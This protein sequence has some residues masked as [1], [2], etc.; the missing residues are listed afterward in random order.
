MCG[1][2]GFVGNWDKG[3]KVALA[4]LMGLET[5]VRGKD[6]TGVFCAAK[7]DYFSYKWAVPANK[8]FTGKNLTKIAKIIEKST[9]FIGHNRMASIGQVNNE[10]AHPFMSNRYALVHNGTYQ[11]AVEEADKKGLH[12]EGTTDSE[13]ILAN[14]ENEGLGYLKT[15]YNSAIVLYDMEEDC[16]YMMRSGNPLWVFRK[17]K[18]SFFFCSTKT[19]GNEVASNFG[20]EPSKVFEIKENCLYKLING[21]LKIVDKWE[22][23]FYEKPSFI[24]RRRVETDR[25]AGRVSYGDWSRALAVYG[26]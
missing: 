3:R 20:I 5:M 13:A 1:I 17:D 4:K 15:I 23:V 19:I 2:Y 12:R 16:L 6:S 11:K 21:K 9:V 10:N 7:E 25:C 26:D 18:R 24:R 14:I 8:F 22:G